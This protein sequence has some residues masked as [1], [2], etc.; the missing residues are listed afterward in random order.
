M[1]SVYRRFCGMHAI[2]SPLLQT[3]RICS[4]G[5]TLLAFLWANATLAE[6]SPWPMHGQN[7]QRSGQSSAL[8][9]SEQPQRLWKVNLEANSYSQPAI[10]ADGTIYATNDNGKL[11]AVSPQ[12]QVLWTHQGAGPR[13]SAPAVA[14]DGAIY[15]GAG[16]HMY[17]LTPAGVEQ[18]SFDVGIG[19][20]ER[21]IYAP[22]IDAAGTVH[23]GTRNGHYALRPNGTPLWHFTSNSTG[24]SA[25]LR[26]GDV[27]AVGEVSTA[28]RLTRLSASTGSVVW[29]TFFPGT[30][31]DPVVAPDESI[32]LA[33]YDG[34]LFRVHPETG[35]STHVS[36][37]PMDG[38]KFLSIANDGLLY[39]NDDLG[40]MKVT[41][42]GEVLWTRLGS[43]GRSGGPLIDRDY[44]IISADGQLGS[45]IKAYTTGG[46]LLWSFNSEETGWHFTTPILGENGVIYATSWSYN[47]T[48]GYLYAIPE[49]AAPLVLLTGAAL[50]LRR[51]RNTLTCGS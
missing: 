41:A 36:T 22:A 51:R 28:R 16:Q 37:L 49:P 29:Q 23:V 24:V 9:E 4:A 40:M 30:T 39:I 31:S 6:A 15:Y 32:F 3:I 48:T 2:M 46:T 25:M 5:C 26:N 42:N 34:A 18:W 27:L 21:W 45:R 1:H 33:D 14:P 20:I 35:V 12:G 17:S 8:A 13:A 19:Y 38:L 10:A 43:G 11:F 7:P 50:M 47:F 44:K